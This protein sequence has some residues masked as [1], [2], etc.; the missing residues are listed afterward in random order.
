M[1]ASLEAFDE[2]ILS[3]RWK[4]PE[5]KEATSPAGAAEGSFSGIGHD[6]RVS[7][8]PLTRIDPGVLRESDPVGG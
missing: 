1:A 4:T 5:H 7:A 8:M 2:D 6:A 3:G